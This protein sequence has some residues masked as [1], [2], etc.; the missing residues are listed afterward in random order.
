M[1]RIP[2]AGWLSLPAVLWP[3]WAGAVLDLAAARTWRL[4]NGLTVI[5]LEEHT[6]PLVSVQML[7]EVGARNEDNGH[8]GLAH[9]LEHMA[10][11]A[12]RNFPGTEIVSSIYA[13]GGEWHGYTWI[14]QTTYF[15]TLPKAELDLALRIEADRMTNL[16]IAAD[17]VEAER[18]A[19]LTELH[20]YD[21]DPAS[22]MHDAL[23]ATAL[24]Q[25]PYRNNTIGW[26]S[27]VMALGHDDLVEFY[28][29]HY[30][31][32]NAV[33]AVVGDV[34][35]A[36]VLGRVSQLF[37]A[38]AAAPATPAVPTVE[39]QQRG[40]RRIALEGAGDRNLF[41][42]AYPA[43]AVRDADFPAFLLLQEILA[44]GSG[45]NFWQTLG[46]TP[47]GEDSLLAIAAGAASDLR[48]WLSPAEFP[49][50]FTISGSTSADAPQ[51]DTEAAIERAVA[52]LRD[53]EVTAETL[54]S[55][56][57]RLLE[58][59]VFDVETTADAAHELAFFGGLHALGARLELP[60][61]IRGVTAAELQRTAQRHL[62]SWQGTIGWYRV[63]QAP[64]VPAEATPSAAPGGAAASPPRVTRHGAPS[65]PTVAKLGAGLTAIVERSP[66]S[67]AV[68]VG[69]LLPGIGPDLPPSMTTSSLVAGYSALG[70]RALPHELLPALGKL[71]VAIEGASARPALVTV[72]GDL[73]PRAA[74]AM[75]RK[76]F[77]S[78]R[79]ADAKPAE[80]MAPARDEARLG[81]QTG[82]RYSVPAP[83]PAQPQAL[84]WQL[85]LYVLSH[86]YEGRLG[87][88]A[89]RNGGLVYDIDGRYESDGARAWIE[90]MTAVDSRKLAAM[91]ALLR[92]E[93]QRL[94]ED[95]PTAAEL[96]E[97]RQHMLGREQTAAQ[98]NE[99]I[100]AELARQ[101]LWYGKLREPGE[102]ARE[103]AA[104]TDAE[105]RDI[106]PAFTGGTI[107]TGET[108]E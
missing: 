32:A 88:E 97:A 17:E 50:L 54:S 60:E 22:V 35:A 57:S 49:Y 19:V 105:V 76:V 31:P 73:D 65:A 63:G 80:A 12:T 107:T 20:G 86:G 64:S 92:E 71:R 52:A 42:I 43:P 13:A 11:R 95:P 10:F 70:V 82:L 48:T 90:L 9:F 100:A 16:V 36:D 23:V 74:Q 38:I 75:L 68:Y 67:P 91:E 61:L 62:Q 77:G 15:E 34:S 41:E 18:G 93:L 3:G 26:P 5:V 7:Y 79:P 28:R 6:A 89:I 8:T 21:D 27:D 47:A 78:M 98:S 102:L 53:R 30:R 81:V 4:D 2:L 46:V 40:E 37:G 59:L 72:V 25:H 83:A 96:A 58:E 29:R 94:R 56:R 99:E 108:P 103:L 104:V 101:W 66:R 69:A 51:A 85:A 84:A 1:R 45:V 87:I 55:A 24:L 33:L 44:G 14:D 106:L 39:P